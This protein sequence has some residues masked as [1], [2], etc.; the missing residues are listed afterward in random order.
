M[1]KIILTENYVAGGLDTFIIDL[2]SELSIK[3]DI[4]FLCNSSHPGLS[5]IKLNLN[6]NIEFFDYNFFINSLYYRGY[7]K[8]GIY[9]NKFFLQLLSLLRKI[10]AYP[11]LIYSIFHWWRFFKIQMD[12]LCIQ[13]K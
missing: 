12:R 8:K 2:L 5:N 6:K 4:L 13:S 7:I 11:F 9:S 10:M 1:K 3:E